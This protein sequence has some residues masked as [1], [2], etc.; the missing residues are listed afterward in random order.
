MKPLIGITGNDTSLER[1][2][3]EFQKDYTPHGFPYAVNKAD[4]LA[5]IIPIQE[6]DCVEDYIN[7]I[8]GLLV[9]GGQDV[10]PILY[11]E[12]PH[13]KLTGNYMKRDEW[14]IKLIKAA[15]AAGKPILAICRGFQL[16]N[17]VLGGTLYQ[18]DSLR[19]KRFVQHTQQ[20]RMVKGHHHVKIKENSI[21]YPMFGD[22]LFVNSYHHQ[23]I[24]QISKELLPI[25]WSDDDLIEAYQDQQGTIL[26]LQWHPEVM[27]FDNDEMLPCFTWLIE[28]AKKQKGSEF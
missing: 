6:H 18:D 8:D 23:S 10:T 12:E 7:S 3:E 15:M 4:G 26:G 1:N 22:K 16:I 28:Q 11:G 21:L 5:M 17:V 14:E 2:Y 24:K 13:P 9:T 25:A 19:Q 20:S 27:L